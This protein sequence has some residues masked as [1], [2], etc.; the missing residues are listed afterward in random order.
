MLYCRCFSWISLRTWL[1]TFAIWAVEL[2]LQLRLYALYGCSRRIAGLLL[3]LFALQVSVL[4]GLCT[5][6][7]TIEFTK[8]KMHKVGDYVLCMP[9]RSSGAFYGT[10]WTV[11][12]SFEAFVL[13]LTLHKGYQNYRRRGAGPLLTDISPTL[14][15]DSIV[16]LFFVE[17]A[18]VANAVLAYIGWQD[19][20]IFLSGLAYV[21]PI[22]M[23]SR[24]TINVRRAFEEH[25]RS[26]T[27][28]S[29]VSLNLTVLH[30]PTQY[31]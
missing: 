15:Q 22:V 9:L 20:V 23:G 3:T 6:G 17:T 24:M 19:D 16:Y 10:Y 26:P 29:Q 21:M 25:L 8:S 27:S 7:T 12:A 4:V 13:G 28:P 1:G 2:V 18:Y 5:Y 31:V 30:E 14:L 11:L